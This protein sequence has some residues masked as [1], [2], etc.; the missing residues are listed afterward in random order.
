VNIGYSIGGKMN[1]AGEMS[2]RGLLSPE[3]PVGFHC[4]PF[5]SFL[6]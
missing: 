2:E 5:L 3:G 4:F 1:E 6:F